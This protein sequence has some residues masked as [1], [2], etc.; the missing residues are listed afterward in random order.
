MIVMLCRSRTC[1]SLGGYPSCLSLMTLNAPAT[2][3]LNAG[4][5]FCRHLVCG[6]ADSAIC[7]CRLLSVY[8]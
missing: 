6:K 7:M 3:L 2:E 5:W 1:L 8:R 4:S